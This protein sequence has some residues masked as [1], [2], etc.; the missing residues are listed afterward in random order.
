MEFLFQVPK[1]DDGQWTCL[2]ND[3]FNHILVLAHPNLPKGI[4]FYYE[5]IFPC[6]GKTNCGL[7][8]CQEAKV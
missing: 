7:T 3:K 4:E 2:D 5:E 6:P 1:F 8:V